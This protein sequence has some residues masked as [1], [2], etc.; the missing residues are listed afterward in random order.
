[1]SKEETLLGARQPSIVSAFMEFLTCYPR[2]FRV[3][4]FILVL[5][6]LVAARLATFIMELVVRL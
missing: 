2:Q 1:M 6:G 5:E 4:F 3:L